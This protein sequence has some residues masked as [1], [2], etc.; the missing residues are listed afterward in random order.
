MYRRGFPECLIVALLGG[1]ATVCVLLLFILIF[2]SSPSEWWRELLGAGIIRTVNPAWQEV[3]SLLNA[4]AA[5]LGTLALL[6][7]FHGAKRLGDEIRAANASLPE[8]HDP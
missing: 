2:H 3:T 1:C 6:V 4:T 7:N 5:V 8:Q